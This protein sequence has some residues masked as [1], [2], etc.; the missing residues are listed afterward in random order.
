MNEQKNLTTKKST[1]EKMNELKQNSTIEKI[2]AENTSMKIS[3]SIA[4]TPIKKSEK[5]EKPKMIISNFNQLRANVVYSFV[6][7]YDDEPH[8]CTAIFCEMFI[9]ALNN[10][11]ALF[12]VDHNVFCA[13]IT[14]LQNMTAIETT[15]I[16]KPVFKLSK[17]K[18][19]YK[20]FSD[21]CSENFPEFALKNKYQI[22]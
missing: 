1:V 12:A 22:I 18:K 17:I 14:T 20:K 15:K 21:N 5:I 16:E 3:D 2:D 13:D 19:H 8:R 11:C 10:T 4:E 9:D 6:N 7:Q